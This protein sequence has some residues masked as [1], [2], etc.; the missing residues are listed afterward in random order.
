MCVYS[1]IKELYRSL[2]VSHIVIVLNTC[3]SV[4]AG[5]AVWL[6]YEPPTD[7][8]PSILYGVL[9]GLQLWLCFFANVLLLVGKASLKLSYRYRASPA[10]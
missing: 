3:I 5:L 8:A 7:A 9:G 2:V 4:A 1:E 6:F 10:I